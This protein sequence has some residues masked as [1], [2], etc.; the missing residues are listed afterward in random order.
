TYYLNVGDNEINLIVK[1]QDGEERTYTVKVVR[2]ANNNAYLKMIS[3]TEETIITNHDD[4][5]Y[6]INVESDIDT[7]TINPIAEESTTTI[8]PTEI[9]LTTLNTGDNLVTI[10]TTAENGDTLTYT[11]NIRKS[12]S[13]NNRLA[14]L[15][16]EEGAL[17]PKFDPDTDTYEVKVAR[18]V[19][20]G[21]FHVTLEDERASYKIT[22]DKNFVIGENTV[23]ITVTSESGKPHDY[24]VKV[25]RQEL[26]SN[27]LLDLNVK[28]VIT[29]KAYPLDQPFAKEQLYYEVTVPYEETKVSVTGTLEDEDA[30]ITGLDDYPLAVGDNLIVIEITSLDGKIRNYQIKVTRTA[31]KDARLKEL[32]VANAILSPSFNKDTFNYTTS[33]TASSLDFKKITTMDE[34]AT[35][36]IIGNSFTAEGTNQV[37]IRVYAADNIH[38]E[39]YTINVTKLPSDNNNLS[40]LKVDGFTIVPNF[41]SSTTFYTLTVPNNI[42]SVNVIAKPDDPN[43]T[44]TGDGINYLTTGTNNLIV[45]VTSESGKKKSYVI[46]VTKEASDDNTLIDLRVI[47]GVLSDPYTNEQETYDVSIPYEVDELDL[48][49][50]LNNDKATYEVIGNESLSVGSNT[51]KVIV[52][53]ENGD[54]KTITLNV[55]RNE[56]VSALIETLTIKNYHPSPEFNSHIFNYDILINNETDKL[57]LTYTTLDKKAT[58]LVIGNENLK[59]G[60]NEIKIIVTSSDGKEQETYTLN[61]T[62][63]PFAN[64]TLD[65]LYTSLGDLTPEFNGT[66]ME[67]EIEVPYQKSSIELFGEALDKTATVTGLGVKSLNV[68]ENNFEVVV[69]T[70]SGVKRVYYVKVIRGFDL[71]NYL[72]TLDVKIG[73]TSYALTPTFD[74]YTNEY[75]LTTP[76]GFECIN[77]IGTVSEN[78]TTEDLGLRHIN[79]G[80]NT[81][82]IVVTSQGG[83]VNVYTINVTRE[84]SDNNRLI[85]IIPSI[86]EL[87]PDFS[88]EETNY[89]INLDSSAAFLSFDVITEYDYATVSGIDA[90]VVPDG[91]STRIIT[92]TSETGKDRTYTITINKEK[93]DNALLD[94]LSVTGYPF[95]E[96]FASN[97]FEYH[98][99]VPNDKKILLPSEVIA[100]PQD[101]NATVIKS[102][103][104]NLLT[105]SENE[106]IVRVTAKDGFTTQDYKI[107]I[108]REKSNIAD[109][110]NLEV[111]IGNLTTTFNPSVLEYN[112]LIPKVST[113][114]KEDV[115]VTPMDLN[116]IIT[117]TESLTITEEGPN[118]FEVT[119]ESEDGTNTVTYKLNISYEL[120]DDK[121]ASSL[122]IDKGYYEPKF[123]KDVLTYD[124]YEYIDTDEINIT[125][126]ASSE[127]ATV[128]GNGTLT[129]TEPEMTHI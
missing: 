2:A 45:E 63:Q 40:E 58:S 37:I 73:A 97:Q 81:V 43:A 3:T 32:Y 88:Y 51:V 70:L 11:L 67:Y 56:I 86:G 28:G 82:N 4:L 75:S 80:P 39:D 48:E 34:N 91:T 116:A 106:F 128:T 53:A 42:N 35:Y 72:E 36:E 18:S 8:D 87:E 121:T 15:I 98:I 69:E 1:S 126:T 76:A 60:S 27:Y 93:I 111:N 64:D 9:N 71:N 101:S 52:S 12:A 125:L 105:T 90:E 20:R 5:S 112:W 54:K 129:L 22:G 49:V 25:I 117:K 110:L 78:S 61:V 44:V 14:D 46:V 84:A 66:T 62:K 59:V 95:D 55:T 83:D 79:I 50:V 77:L 23:T 29:N 16:M 103:S 127:F 102:N 123:N 47:N 33:T 7:I 104:L 10:I 89:T 99:H 100:I 122:V 38:T 41:A 24:T 21:T 31:S 113:V 30:T 94:S 65:Y 109:L 68:G 114:T 108:E 19:T 120:S 74:K 107:Y 6:E 96:V 119:V 92:V 115:T 13:D 124:V 17:K 57:D 26:T 85:S 118:I